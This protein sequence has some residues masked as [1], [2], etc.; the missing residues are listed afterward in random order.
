MAD[1]NEVNV[2][3]GATI[4]DLK[5]KMDEVTGIFKTVTERFAVLAAVVAGGAA[6][7][8][9]IDESNTLN[10]E[11][12]KLSRTLGITGEDAGTLNTALGDIGTDADTYTGA[13]V[14]F[15]RQLRT[16]S[17]EMRTMGVDVDGLKNGQ[18]SS[19]EV[20]QEAIRIVGQYKP[21][22]DQTQ[23]AMKLF[24]R[25]VEDVQKLQRLTNE[26]LEEAKKKNEELN[27]VITQ[28]GVAASKKYKEAMNDVHDVMD[29]LGKTIGEA[30]IPHFTEM[31]QKLAGIG[32]TL[33]KG[34]QYLSQMFVN[35]W[36]R[37]GES[38]QRTWGVVEGVLGRI[39]GAIAIA[40]GAGS[41]TPM[42][43]FVKALQVVQ[44]VFVALMDVVD[45]V[46]STVG[47]VLGLLVAV[48]VDVAKSLF[49]GM[50]QIVGLFTDGFGDKMPSAMEIFRNALAVVKIAFIAFRVGVEEVVVV[51]ET[52]LAVLQSGFRS[53]AAVAMAALH[54]DWSGAKSAWA[55]G[56]AESNAILQQGM[57]KA[58]GIARQGRDDIETAALNTGGSKPLDIKT[59]TPKGAPPG[60]TKT[61]DFEKGKND[62]GDATMAAQL[63]LQKAQE[64]AS[65]KLT[66]EFLGETQRWYDDAYRNGIVSTREY[67][68]AKAAIEVAGIDETLRARRKEL[69]NAQKAD[70]EAHASAGKSVKP[71]ERN[72]YEAQSLKFQTEAAKLTGEVNVLEAQRTEAVRKTSAE[73]AN[74]EKKIAEQVNQ[75]KITSARDAAQAQIEIEKGAIDQKRSLNEVSAQE[76]L[77]QLRSLEER[78]YAITIE[79]LDQKRAAIHGSDEEV[80][81]ARVQ[82]LADEEGAERQH[83]QRMVEIAR[84]AEVERKKYSIEAQ[85]SIQGSFANMISQ[86]LNGVTKLSDIFRNFAK[87][88]TQTFVD[89]I[90]KNF[91]EHIFNVTGVKKA[92]DM[93]VGFVT[94]GIAM[95]VAKFLMKETT[96]SAIAAAGAANRTA[97]NASEAAATA[98]QT[99]AETTEVVAGEA[100]KTTAVVAGGVTRATAEA[101]A[102][103]AS[104]AAQQAVTVAGVLGYA[105]E[106]AVA[107]MASVAAIP[108]VGWAMAP[109]VGAATYATGLAY[110]ASA[111]GGWD[112]VPHDQLTELHR[113]EMVLSAPLAEGI[114]KMVVKGGATPLVDSV[115][116]IVDRLGSDDQGPG[117]PSTPNLSQPSHPAAQ[118]PGSDVGKLVMRW[119]D[120][121]ENRPLSESPEAMSKFQSVNAGQP[122]APWR[123]PANP[124]GRIQAGAAAAAPSGAGALAG[125]SRQGDVHL[126]V[127]AVDAA[128]VR[129]LFMDN[130]PALSDALRKQARNFPPA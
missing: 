125:S 70:A 20:F 44:D 33:V 8:G 32:P 26:K 121:E 95:I 1:T 42:E 77:A 65:V 36:E 122:A 29:G 83:Q 111:R 99:T 74:V 2:K 91:A 13:F 96:E 5:S 39:L 61:F 34:M 4:D 50:G 79:Y 102:A 112:E 105:A 11:A 123:V 57:E 28:E 46:V 15:N 24:G 115:E 58:A 130:G 43:L 97:L 52:G 72:K 129:R 101:T 62:K 51:V 76:A 92:I 114:R 119:M 94:D 54:L 17:D 38:V 126:H 41:L 27:L 14:K 80:R 60:G 63:A 23:A 55:A 31:A 90:S 49:D 45:L 10:S 82:Q 73:Y 107:A 12:M 78:S 124:L 86:L 75:I 118:S 53:F 18:K 120:G 109:E 98:A 69:E 71:E 9:F 67:Y 22:I 117:T 47:T 84:Q 25:S 35:V 110:L 88:V 113:S 104:I 7:K 66:R 81:V 85:Q 40:F 103:T 30:V 37:I 127:S 100:T 93:A 16:N 56:V 59:G 116:R 87:A 68:D 128:S 89:L 64:E 3:F 21:G 19:N 48:F 6:F 106:A 108:F